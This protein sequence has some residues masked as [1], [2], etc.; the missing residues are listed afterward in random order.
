M[1]EDWSIKDR[2]NILIVM[3]EHM[4]G[5]V[6]DFDH[7]CYMPNIKNRLAREGM[8]FIL[9][10]TPTALCAPARASFFTGLYPTGHGMYNNYH[11]LPVMHSGLFLGVKLFSEY[12]KEVSYNLSYI[13]KWH[14]SGEKGPICYGWHIPQEVRISTGYPVPGYRRSLWEKQLYRRRSKVRLKRYAVIKRLG[15]PDYILYG[16][17]DGKLEEMADFKRVKIAAKEIKRLSR[18]SKPWVIF[19]GL[20]NL[21]DPYIVPEPYASMYDP[22][23][24]SLPENYYDSLE[25]KPMI[26]RRMRQQLWSQLNGQQVRE[27][28]AHY[29]GLC[30]MTDDL[31]SLLL[32]ALEDVGVEDNTLVL[33]T[34]DHGD[35]VGG[36]GLF[37]KGVMPFEESY[38]IPMIV[39]WPQV[40]KPGSISTE[41]VTL[42]DFAPT[43]C[44]IAGAEMPKPCHGRSLLPLFQGLKPKDWPQSFFGQF[45]GSEYY[46]TQRIIR[47]YR[48]K[49]VFNAFD[50]DELYDLQNDPYEMKNLITDPDYDDIKIELIKEMWKWCVKTDDI[51]FDPYPTSALIPY[52]PL[53][54]LNELKDKLRK[55]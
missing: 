9:G 31:V 37:L 28:I 54:Y 20:T 52:G 44:E 8:T 16:T 11:S 42:C 47:T 27:A 30:T 14:V 34:S 49:Y 15:W 24:I 6:V 38:R 17:L 7:P 19:V 18:K 55:D 40:I 12:L 26:Y 2:P 48:F 5:Q 39:R 3:Q 25:D 50:I 43:F 33:F 21:H 36:H 23:D 53:I 46:Y 13:G 41:F 45:L 51:L 1:S 22:D 4:Q 35:Q 10:Y 29:W 32:D